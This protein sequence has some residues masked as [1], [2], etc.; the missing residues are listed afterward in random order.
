MN[1]TSDE[2]VD[3]DFQRHLQQLGS[4][5]DPGAGFCSPDFVFW[6]VNR[7]PALLLVGMRALLMQ[8]AHPKV[9][10][11]VADHS[12]Y[13]EAPLGRGIRTFTAMY[14]IIFGERDEA[15][16]LA[17]RVRMIHNRVH[18]RVADPLPVGMTSDY[19]ATDP[20]LLFW[21]TA[22]LLDSAVI[23]YEHFVAPLDSDE[24]DEFLRAA[25]PLGALFGIP[26]SLYPDN[27]SAFEAWM[28]QKL[29]S[30][31]L[32]VTPT[33]QRIFRSL[34]A[35]TGFTRLLSPFN[36]AMAAM[37]LPQRLA[38]MYGM[39]RSAGVRGLFLAMVWGTRLLV[40]LT[41]WGLRGVPAARRGERRYRQR[42][43]HGLPRGP[44][45]HNPAATTRTDH[46]A[47]APADRER[48]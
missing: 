19:D 14:R 44:G 20:E 8:I 17:L 12:R 46:G 6:R 30:G 32:T 47:D 26:G 15:M 4:E 45:G 7:E 11:G 37:L 23:A 27:W 40:R 39:R 13:R 22:T 38:G 36:Y 16:T 21:V 1:E 10:Q 31:T 33:A 29:N 2:A 28:A 41:P 34:L 25:K 24:K 5:I 3:R 35:G 9:A 48:D 42:R 43:S 18:G